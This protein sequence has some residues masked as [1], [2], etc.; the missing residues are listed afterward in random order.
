MQRYD[1]L[2][3]DFNEIAELAAEFEGVSHF[4][5][6]SFHDLKRKVQSMALSTHRP[7][8]LPK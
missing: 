2:C 8:F 4:F 3:K 5:Q 6:N 7:S 1:N